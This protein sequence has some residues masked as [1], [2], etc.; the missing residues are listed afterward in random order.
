MMARLNSVVVKFKIDIERTAIVVLYMFLKLWFIKNLLQN[1]QNVSMNTDWIR[2]IS[3]ATVIIYG[4]N[5]TNLL[6]CTQWKI[7]KQGIKLTKITK[8]IPGKNRMSSLFV[9]FNPSISHM[10][11]KYKNLCQCEATHKMAGSWKGCWS[12]LL[13]SLCIHSEWLQVHTVKP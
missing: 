8:M 6:V 3:G 7:A 5:I 4:G 1:Q 10:V 2:T 13:L 12:G 11:V 9:T